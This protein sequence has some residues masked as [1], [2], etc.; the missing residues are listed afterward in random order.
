[1]SKFLVIASDGHYH[2]AIREKDLPLLKDGLGPWTWHWHE[3]DWWGPIKLQLWFTG[4]ED[5]PE[6]SPVSPTSLSL[7]EPIEPPD[8][9]LTIGGIYPKAHSRINPTL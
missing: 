9:D 6:I 7:P 8:L 5:A 1:M 2:F 3:G 4:V